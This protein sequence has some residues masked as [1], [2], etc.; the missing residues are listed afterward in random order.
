ML[1]NEVVLT[2]WSWKDLLP[3]RLDVV[4][5]PMPAKDSYGREDVKQLN[6]QLDLFQES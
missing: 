6:Y 4:G 2:E 3:Q 5:K 1:I